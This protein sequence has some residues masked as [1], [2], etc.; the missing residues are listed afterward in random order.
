MSKK[1]G[2][3]AIIDNVIENEVNEQSSKNAEEQAE[4]QNLDNET[5]PNKRKYAVHS[6]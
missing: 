3:D 5:E 6:L 1:E 2:K 4:K